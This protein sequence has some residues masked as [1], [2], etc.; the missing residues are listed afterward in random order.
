M[1]SLPTKPTKGDLG[2]GPSLPPR[3]II[4]LPLTIS[5]FPNDNT[6]QLCEFG[7]VVWQDRQR[8]RTCSLKRVKE[9]NKPAVKA[10]YSDGL[11]GG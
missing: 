4:Y 8:S 1:L 11:S 10:E 5:L 2:W 9:A 7:A 6:T 3:E